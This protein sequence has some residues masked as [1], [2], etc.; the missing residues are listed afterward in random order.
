MSANPFKDDPYT[1]DMGDFHTTTYD[2]EQSS[3]SC[4]C[5]ALSFVSPFFTSSLPSIPHLSNSSVQTCSFEA[6]AYSLWTPIH[7]VTNEL[8][9]SAFGRSNQLIQ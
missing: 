6:L 4:K 2:P 7:L 1:F 8:K 9:L 5:I 3:V